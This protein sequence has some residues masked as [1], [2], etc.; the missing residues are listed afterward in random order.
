MRIIHTS[1][2]STRI[3]VHLVGVQGSVVPS[4]R[5]HL[6]TVTMPRLF[7]TKLLFREVMKFV[8]STDE[9]LTKES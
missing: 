3:S 4:M 1:Q 5:N 7:M 9:Q 2:R 8:D 6:K